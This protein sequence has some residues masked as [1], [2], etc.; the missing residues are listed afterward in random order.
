MSDKKTWSNL[1]QSDDPAPKE[2]ATAWDKMASTLAGVTS[3]AI[4]FAAEQTHAAGQDLVSRVLL[5]ESY[6][7]PEQGKEPEKE[8]ASEPDKDLGMDR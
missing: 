7:P 5:G 6:S 1:L 3:F 4:G 8:R 2:G